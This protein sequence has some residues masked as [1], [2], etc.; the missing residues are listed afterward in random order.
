M[1]R[2]CLV[3]TKIDTA[4]YRYLNHV[5]KAEG[6]SVAAY[7]RRMIIRD[8]IASRAPLKLDATC[9]NGK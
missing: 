4:L 7:L 3:Q 8:Q 1:T 5:A 6:I 9:T 2:E